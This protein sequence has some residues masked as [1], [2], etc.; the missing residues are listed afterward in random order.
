MEIN[1]KQKLA[2][3]CGENP[4]MVIAGAGSGKTFVLV[5]RIIYLVNELGYHSNS[6]LAFTFTNKAANEIKHRITNTTNGYVFNWIGTFHSICLKI[7]RQDADK[8][9]KS[10]NFMIIDEDEKLSIIKNIYNMHGISKDSISHKKIIS[11]IS[12]IKTL[13]N[14]IITQEDFDNFFLS[15]FTFESEKVNLIK[16]IYFDYEKYL[17]ERDLFDFDDLIVYTL[18]LLKNNQDIRKKWQE[19]FSYILVDEFQDTS[20]HQFELIKLLVKDNKNLFIVGDPDQMIYSWRGAY[21]SIFKDF[22]KVYPNYE[23]IILDQNYRSTKKILDVSNMLINE[24]KERIEKSLFTNNHDGDQVEY[25]HALS[26]NDETR[27]IINKIKG[28]LEL[29]YKYKDILILYRSNYSSRAIEQAL[30]GSSLP[31]TIFGGFKFYQRKEIKDI[32]AYLKLSIY[33][34]DLSISR[35]YNTPKRKI[36]EASF[37]KLVKYANDNNKSIVQALEEIDNIND[38]NTATKNKLNELY[39][40][41]CELRKFMSIDFSDYVDKI[42]SLTKY[43]DY[44]K[45]EDEEYR[46]DNIIE[47]KNSMKQ[48]QN[49]NPKE[50]LMNY[51]QEICLY[52]DSESSSYVENSISLMTV[53]NSKGLEY[54]V[55][56]ITSFNDGDFPSTKALEE[57]GL[58]EER[59][60]AYVAMTRARERLYITSSSGS[61]F[62]GNGFS[63]KIPSR[64]I[65]EIT[66]SNSL[67]K[68]LPDTNVN[69]NYYFN[70]YKNNSDYVNNN[71]LHD[72]DVDFYIGEKVSH[73]MF[74]IGT[75]LKIEG[76]LVVVSFKP[77]FGIKKLLKNHKIIT[78][79][80]N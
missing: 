48:Y 77:P 2:I 60:I 15:E 59:R 32:I 6:I 39:S 11:I 51:L 34:D 62:S 49:E 45:E 33:D 9:N 20:Y 3:E 75:V 42:L 52:T 61:G 35:I 58:D 19:Y 27:W 68:L 70:E 30:V 54:K 37:S 7:L 64:F 28:L 8:L 23:Q 26:A 18:E 40:I 53:H 69:K 50:S 16:I 79:L 36:G 43:K 47:L 10:K 67:R 38:I 57:N 21:S 56:F 66:K 1:N 74:G 41:I 46:I 78:K 63:E 31:Y 22:T 44:L 80:V 29:G 72:E 24:N 14:R 71:H 55:V 25:Y 65:S 5:N 12:S 17:N 4:T 73:K 76:T 13:K